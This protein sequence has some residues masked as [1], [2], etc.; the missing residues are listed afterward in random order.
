[1]AI[2]TER[3]ADVGPKPRVLRIFISYA[4]EDQKIAIAVY[5]AIQTALGTFA[6]VFI[7]DAL[8]LGLNFQ[9][10]IKSRLDQTDV[11]VVI[12]SAALKPSH[13]FTGME[14]GYFIRVVERDKVT[15][16]KRRIIPIY[17]D[18]PP[19]TLLETERINHRISRSTL[20]MTFE[21][22]E[23][24]LSVDGDNRMV[25]FLQ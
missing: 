3:G 12:Y 23:A 10:E 20:A 6:D 25:K 21:E 16:F 22:Y 14:L 17:L 8:R 4:K 9:D 5:N 11:L 18:S 1:M 19:D 7:D 24:N 2:G 15:D 13:G